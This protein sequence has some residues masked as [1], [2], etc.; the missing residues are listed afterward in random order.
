MQDAVEI[1]SPEAADLLARLDQEPDQAAA[2]DPA[3]EIA[4]LIT[5]SAQRRMTAVLAGPNPPTDVADVRRLID[6]VREESAG[7]EAAAQLLGW[8]E[9]QDEER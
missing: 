6:Q 5:N 4:H 1:A 8:L 2:L 9:G 3:I 7:S